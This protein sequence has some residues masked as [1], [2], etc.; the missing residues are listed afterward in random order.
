MWRY[1]GLGL[2]ALAIIVTGFSLVSVD[3]G[4]AVGANAVLAAGDI[5][6]EGFTRATDPNYPW[7]FPEDHGPHP[8]FLTEW[9]YYTGNLA[10]EDGRRFGFQFTIFRRAILPNVTTVSNDSEWRTNQIYLAHFTM[11]D[12]ENQVF[13]HDERL[14]RGAAGLAGATTDPEYRVWLEDWEVRALN[15][16]ATRL[17]MRAATDDVSIDFTLEQG[18]PPVFQ[19]VNGLSAKSGIPGNASYYYSIPR[20]LT[21]GTITIG[22]EVFEVSGNTWMDQ[23]FSTSGLGAEAQGWDWFGLIFDDNTEIMVGQ[24]RL[25]DGGRETAFG[26]LYVYEDASTV[27]LP[28]DSFT[29]TPTAFWTSDYSNAEYPVAWEVEVNIPDGETLRFTATALAE[30]QELH[31]TPTYWEGAVR[32]EGDKTGYG[33]AELTGYVDRMAGFF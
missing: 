4:D 32:I 33:Y 5:D 10:T 30:D 22:D 8:D 11:S 7:E 17:S 26:G 23:E 19:G 14:L 9:W 1:I 3:T 24:I 15:A 2:A 18:K 25:D 31:T 29:I 20:L 21:D 16:D 13:F 27:Y 28:S 12:L 6:L